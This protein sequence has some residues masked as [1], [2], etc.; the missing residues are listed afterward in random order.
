MYRGLLNSN[1][2]LQCQ[3]NLS[4]LFKAIKKLHLKQLHDRI[5]RSRKYPLPPFL[6]TASAHSL[7]TRSRH[8][9]I[10]RLK[11]Q[12]IWSF[13]GTPT[14]TDTSNQR[15]TAVQDLSI[16]L[17]L[18]LDFVVWKIL[19]PTDMYLIFQRFLFLLALSFL[20]KAYSGP[21]TQKLYLITLCWIHIL[22]VTILRSSLVYVV[23]FTE[24]VSKC[25]F[26]HPA[27]YLVFFPTGTLQCGL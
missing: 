2:E 24:L 1:L 27:P 14:D 20:S 6:I 13:S 15:H 17:G 12:I 3:G 10:S 11:H 8:S 18:A 23:G 26:G 25:T 22:Q 19:S 5:R 7:V 4:I 21:I 16:S 9:S